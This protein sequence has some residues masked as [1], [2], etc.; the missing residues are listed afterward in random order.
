M[1]ALQRAPLDDVR[2]HAERRQ[3]DRA[4]DRARATRTPAS[5]PARTTTRSPPRTPPATSAPPSQPGERD[6]RP[7]A[8]AGPRR[9]LRLRR[10]QRH[11]DR[12]PVRQRQ[13][14]HARE[15]HLGRR[16]S[17][18]SATRSP[19]TARTR[20]QRRRQRSLDLTTG[21]TLEAWVKPTALGGWRHGR[22]SRSGPGTY[23]YGAL[24]EHGTQPAVGATSTRRPTTTSAAPPRSPLNTW[25][26]LAATYDGSEL[27]PLRQRRRR[28][29]PWS[30]PARSSPRPARSGSAATRSGAST[31]TA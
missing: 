9:R 13:H 26:H 19:S 24:R 25:T 5:R 21:M 23:A 11:D 3:P 27:A 16:G 2:L 29:R 12:R 15:R 6:R 30:S 14:R 28:P 17:A 1:L 7:R 20:R 8:A 22:S 10:G 18:S 31:S 4:A